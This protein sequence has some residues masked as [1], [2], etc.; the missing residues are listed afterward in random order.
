M[1]IIILLV[2]VC[3]AAAVFFLGPAV[4]EVI[5]DTLE[6]WRKVLED[7]KGGN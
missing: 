7:I 6:E 2:L 3:L 4:L 5:T 1:G